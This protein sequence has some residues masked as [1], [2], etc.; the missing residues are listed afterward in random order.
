M[1]LIYSA[2]RQ[3]MA[4]TGRYVESRGGSYDDADPPPF[5]GFE[6]LVGYY[7]N[8][9]PWDAE[10]LVFTTTAVYYRTHTW[11]RIP[12]HDMISAEPLSAKHGVHGVHIQTPNGIVFLRAAGTDA[13]NLS[14]DA[15]A[16]Y[17]F[18]V[19]VVSARER[20]NL[21]TERKKWGTLEQLRAC[22]GT[23]NNSIVLGDP[24]ARQFLSFGVAGK[25]WSCHVGVA[26]DHG[27]TP[28]AVMLSDRVL[29]VGHDLSLTFLDPTAARTL[30]SY[31]MESVF[32]CFL[33]LPMVTDEVIVLHELGL[34]RVDASGG[35]VWTMSAPDIV[36]NVELNERDRLTLTLMEGETTLEID[37]ATGEVLND[38]A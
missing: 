30:S 16:L 23:A 14:S 18:I 3:T 28:D 2:L 6:D 32:F 29:L 27:V 19:G 1:L 33:R 7:V 37:P 36:A 21:G 12:Y 35:I 26:L 10:P 13:Q 38:G 9:A 4:K 22:L 17:S 15:W 5:D 25:G 34:L 31:T 11:C 8:P 20:N 24:G